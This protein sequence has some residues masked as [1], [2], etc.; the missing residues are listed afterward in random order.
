M[1]DD[2]PPKVDAQGQSSPPDQRSVLCHETPEELS[3]N[4]GSSESNYQ[5]TCSEARSYMYI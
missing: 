1:L 4:N 5:Q 3:N 2:D